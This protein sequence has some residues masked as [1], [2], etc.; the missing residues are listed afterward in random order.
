MKFIVPYLHVF[1]EAFVLHV[2][3]IVPGKPFHY[4]PVKRSSP[5]YR[6][7]LYMYN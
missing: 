1:P 4:I 6:L 3:G 5:F 2:Y 7:F